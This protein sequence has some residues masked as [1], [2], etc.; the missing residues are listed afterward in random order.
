MLGWRDHRTGSRLS[1]TSHD[2]GRKPRGLTLSPTAAVRA[3]LKWQPGCDAKYRGLGLTCIG[4]F[5]HHHHRPVR[6]VL[7]IPILQEGTQRQTEVRRV[8]VR[9]L[10]STW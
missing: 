10:G 2:T 5:H 1:A 4:P 7:I 9:G 6:E 8:A 3:V